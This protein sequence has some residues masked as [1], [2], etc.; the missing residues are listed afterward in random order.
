MLLW[1]RS[2][3]WVIASRPSVPRGR[4]MPKILCLCFW[5]RKKIKQIP[6]STT[7]SRW[8]SNRTT[9][10]VSY[11]EARITNSL[12]KCLKSWWNKP[13]RKD[14]VATVIPLNPCFPP[15]IASKQIFPSNNSDHNLKIHL[16]GKLNKKMERGCHRIRIFGARSII[17]HSGDTQSNPS[18]K[19]ITYHP[20]NSIPRSSMI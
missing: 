5:K 19:W 9:N 14:R 10:R 11:S 18:P 12:M 20:I 16:K 17:S 13:D 7:I 3:R 8:S 2:K 6:S 15:Q 4:K 1:S